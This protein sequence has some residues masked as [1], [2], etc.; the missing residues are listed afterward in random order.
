MLPTEDLKRLLTKL[1]KAGAEKINFAG[2]EPFLYPKVLGDLV[3]HAKVADGFPSVSVISNGSSFSNRALKAG[4]MD[5]FFEKLG[6]EHLDMLG[7]SCDSVDASTNLAIGRMEAGAARAKD[8]TDDV[9]NAAGFARRYGQRFKINTVGMYQSPSHHRLPPPTD[10]I[11]PSRR[12]S[13]TVWGPNKLESGVANLINELEIVERW[14][15][16]QALPIVGENTPLPAPAGALAAEVAKLPGAGRGAGRSA[17]LPA[18]LVTHAEF[19]AFVARNEAALTPALR[20][21]GII[22]DEDNAAMQS[23]YILVDELGRFLDSS[24]G[25]KTPTQPILKVG[26]NAAAAELLG[27]NGRGFDREAWVKRDGDFF[28]SWGTPSLQ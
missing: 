18:M 8:H 20:A 15:I 25:A 19:K 14:K 4:L 2:G 21:K 3:R 17:G 27:D 23:S 24:R 7:I 16:F 22:K 28:K 9:R 12:Q 6:G 5:K 13:R 26:L 1:R 10:P 11:S